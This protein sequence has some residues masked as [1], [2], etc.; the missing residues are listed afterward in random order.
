MILD[1]IGD[2]FTD[3]RQLKQFVFDDDLTA[4]LVAD[5]WSLGPADSQANPCCTTRRNGLDNRYLTK[6]VSG[7]TIAVSMRP[8]QGRAGPNFGKL[9]LR[10]SQSAQGRRLCPFD[11]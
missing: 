8:D 3:R 2:F 6:I 10:T 11:R 4:R 9:P 7:P 5:T 1:V